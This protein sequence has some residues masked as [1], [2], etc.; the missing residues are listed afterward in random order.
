MC[1]GVI[2][3]KFTWVPTAG[4]DLEP[5]KNVVLKVEGLAN[6]TGTSGDCGNGINSQKV[7]SA[8]SGSS[9]ATET[10]IKVSGASFKVVYAP[11]AWS[12]FQPGETGVLSGTAFAGL[13]VSATP[14]VIDPQGTITG[15][16]DARTVFRMP[17]IRRPVPRGSM[18]MSQMK[19]M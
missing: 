15:C 10:Y 12:N 18:T 9:F 19:W 11:Y 14:V 4:A 1:I 17:N 8:E 16:S 7:A 13:K 3:A 6:W 5:P 2:E